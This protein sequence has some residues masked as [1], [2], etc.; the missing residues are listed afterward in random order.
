ML[1]AIALTTTILCA[2]ATGSEGAINEDNVAEDDK[3]VFMT[4]LGIPAFMNGEV[5]ML[6]LDELSLYH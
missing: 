4:M 3:P 6:Q 1:L 2:I 5:L